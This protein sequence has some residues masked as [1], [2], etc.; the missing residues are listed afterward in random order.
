MKMQQIQLEI[1]SDI[2]DTVLSFLDKLPQNKIKLKL[3]KEPKNEE[4]KDIFA[5]T[6]GLLSAKN[7]DPIQWQNQMRSEWD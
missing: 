2:V 4:A 7:I 3:H 5:S 6:S 1:S